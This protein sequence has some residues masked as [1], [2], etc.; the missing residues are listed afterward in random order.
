MDLKDLKTMIAGGESQTV[1]FKESFGEETLETL[2]AFA[3]TSGGI[4][5]VGAADNAAIVGIHIGKESLR[6][7]ANRIT[8]VT[9]L[10]PAISRIDLNGKSIVRIAVAESPVK[11]VACSGRYFKRVNNSNRRM[12]DD[13]ITRVV[14]EKVGAT[15]DEI[16]EPR[17]TLADISKENLASFRAAC[18]Q[19]RRRIVPAKD[20]VTA[21]LEKL[22]LI[23]KGKL[24]R[25]AVLLFGNEP[26][27][28]YP[29]A[30]LK[31]GRFRPGGVIADDKE[32]R[33]TLFTQIE[34]AMEYFREHLQTRFEFS[35]APAREVI[36]EYPLEALR[37][38]VTNAVCHR[39]YL[40]MSQT[41]IRWHDDKILIVN[42]GKLIPP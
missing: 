6:A 31:I 21:V 1:E 34:H 14:L 19:K 10:N 18:N 32:I 4:I 12:T 35:G 8:Q 3:N 20:S 22:G 37:E 13:D 42:P 23:K 38:A 25:A 11:P 16:I 27:S 41:Q 9:N 26:Q 30:F 33:G 5:L 29:S 2:A 36:W 39:D 17:A 24:L 7:W 40:D 15:W 28:F